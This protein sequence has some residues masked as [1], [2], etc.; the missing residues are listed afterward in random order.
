MD[1]LGGPTALPCPTIW[2]LSMCMCLPHEQLPMLVGIGSEGLIGLMEGV[3]LPVA[4]GGGGEVLLH[5][6][7]GQACFVTCLLPPSM[8][9]HCKPP[10]SSHHSP[11][12][13]NRC[14]SSCG[15]SHYEISKRY[16]STGKARAKSLRNLIVRRCSSA[17]NCVSASC[18]SSIRSNPP[19]VRL[20]HGTSNQRAMRL[21]I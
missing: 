4:G 5:A 14:S 18:P 19:S 8:R 12:C 20:H 10:F 13:S 15:A 1:G 3:R 21:N 9:M 2:H 6:M 17:Y 11:A 16:Q 7:L